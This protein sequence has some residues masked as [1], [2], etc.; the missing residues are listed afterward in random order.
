L[1]EP[2]RL[3]LVVR[4][5]AVDALAQAGE[6]AGAAAVGCLRRFGAPDEWRERPGKV[7]LRARSESQ[8]EAVL[9][10]GHFCAGDGVLALPPQRPSERPPILSRLQAMATEL[11]PPPTAIPD[12]AFTYVLNPDAQ[13]SSG[14]T[15]AQIGHAAVM[16]AEALPAWAD[17]G[18]PAKVAA[19]SKAAFE[20]LCACDR[21][22]AKVVDAGLT[23]VPPGTITVLALRERPSLP[24]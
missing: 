24:A 5:G 19:P 17:D 22:V 10:E 21:C 9:E 8:W 3:Y 1:T 20:Q 6:L 18:C 7:C 14:K 13:M 11:E 2:F 4:R 15:L 16:A 23:E 12:D